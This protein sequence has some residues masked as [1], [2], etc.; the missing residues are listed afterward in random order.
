VFPLVVIKPHPCFPAQQAGGGHVADGDQAK[1]L[2][3]VQ[4]LK[5]GFTSYGIYMSRN[6]GVEFNKGSAFSSLS[7]KDHAIC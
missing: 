3:L 6:L 4:V 1:V 7:T 5:Q 2:R